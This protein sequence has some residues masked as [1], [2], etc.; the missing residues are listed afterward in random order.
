VNDASRVWVYADD[1]RLICTAEWNANVRSFFPV[2]V[3][4]QAARPPC[5][6]P[7]NRLQVHMEEV[8]AERRGQLAIEARRKSL[9]QG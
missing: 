4:E 1:G 8:Q 9:F 5:C 7:V 3:I 6:R 2:S